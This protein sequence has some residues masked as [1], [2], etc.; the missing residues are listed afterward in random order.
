M[1]KIVKKWKDLKAYRLLQKPIFTAES[2]CLTFF[3][4]IF[5]NKN[6]NY[7]AVLTVP[8]YGVCSPDSPIF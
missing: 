3:Y 1:E 7:D 5:H 8:N 4:K 6:S 2:N